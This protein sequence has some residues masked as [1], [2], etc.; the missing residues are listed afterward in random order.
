MD[1]WLDSLSEDWVSQPR[2]P[3]SSPPVLSNTS[4]DSPSPSNYGSQSRIPR[5]KPR[6][7]SGLSTESGKELRPAPSMR[8][9]SEQGALKEKSS[10]NINASQKRLPNGQ[11]KS[12][13]LNAASMRLRGRQASTGSTSPLQQ[14]TVQHKVSPMKASDTQETLE[15]KTRLL[16]ENMGKG[17]LFSPIGLEGVFKPP[18]VNAKAKKPMGRRKLFPMEDFPSSPPQYPDHAKPGKA[19]DLALPQRDLLDE[20]KSS[21]PTANTRKAALSSSNGSPDRSVIA[22]TKIA[23]PNSNALQSPTLPMQKTRSSLSNEQIDSQVSS[24]GARRSEPGDKTRNENISPLYVSRHNTVDGRVEFAAIDMSV[25]RLRSEMEKLR[26]QQQNLPSSRSSDHGIDYTDA[27]LGGQSMLHDRMDEATSQSLPDDLSMGTDAFAANGGFVSLH[28]GGYSN[29][30]SFQRR[31][32]SPSLLPDLDGP[33]LKLPSSTLDHEGRNGGGVRDDLEFEQQET[34]QTAKGKRL[35]CSP[36]KD[37]APKRRRTIRNPDEADEKKFELSRRMETQ[38][39]PVQS[40]HGRKRKDARYDIDQQAADPDAI[41]RRPMLRPR[42]PTLNRA[43]NHVRQMNAVEPSL[44]HEQWRTEDQE[45]ERNQSNQISVD[46]PTQIVAGALATVALNTVQEITGGSRKASVTTAD[47]FNEAQQIMQLLRAKGRPR[48]SHTTAETSEVDHPTI[49]EESVV[50]D[51]TKDEFSRPP[52]R[53]GPSPPKL[54]PPAQLNPRVVSHLRKFEDKEDLG[55]ALSSSL[56]N[57]QISQSNEMSAPNRDDTEADGSESDPPNTRIREST[58]QAH[59]RS[60]SSSTDN[61]LSLETQRSQRY[62]S[63]QSTSGPSTSRSNPTGSSHSSTNRMVIAPETVAHLLAD[64]MAGMAYDHQRQVWVRRKS[65]PK[66]GGMD[67]VDHSA[68]EGTEEDFFR[69]IPDLSVDEMEELQR[70]KE[71]VSSIRSLGSTKDK[72]SVHDLAVS[73][74][75]QAKAENRDKPAVDVRPKTADGKYIDPIDNSSAPSKY[76]HFAF[77]GPAPGTSTR[78]TS[79]GDDALP[80]KEVH[81]PAMARLAVPRNLQEDYDPEVE[82]EISILEGRASPTPHRQN[83]HRQAR[84]VT[85]AFSSPLVDHGELLDEPRD[86]YNLREGNSKW[87]LEDT[88]ARKGT[89]RNLFSSRRTSFGTSKPAARST[90]RRQSISNQSY[91]ARPMSRL[92]EQDEMSLVHCSIG[93]RHMSMKVAVSTPIPLSRSLIAPPMTSQQSGVG[94]FLSPLPDFTV[95]QVDRPVD[96]DLKQT[97]QRR[98]VLPNATAD[99]QL[100][101]AAQDLVKTLTDLQ[102]YEPYWE[103]IRSV[104]LHNR[105]LRSLHMLDEFCGRVEELDVSKNQ[106]RELSGI[107]RSVR[108]L[109][110]RGNCLSDLSAWHSLQNLQYLDVSGNELSSLRGFGCLFHLRALRADDNKLES[111]DGV[112]RLDGL[113][114][115]SL[116]GNKLQTVDF[117]NYDLRRLTH[118]NLSHNELIEVTNMHQLTA[119]ET[120]NLS[121]NDLE[122]LDFSISDPLHKLHTLNISNNKL[123]FIDLAEVPNI[124][125]LNIDKNSVGSIESL[126]GLKHLETLSWRQQDLIPAYGFSEIQYQ[127]CHEVRSLFLSGNHLATFAPSTPFLN[128]HLLELASTGLKTLPSD[129]GLKC[130]NL[131]SLNVNYN[132]IQ[133]L[134]PLLGVL[135]LE[136]LHAAGNR[137]SKLRRTVS[138]LQRLCLELKE[139]DLRSNPLTLGYYTPQESVQGEKCVA[140]QSYKHNADGDD[141]DAEAKAAKAYVLPSVDKEADNASR[142]R[143]DEDTKIRRRVY[144]M[145]VV[146]TC[147]QLQQLDGLPV[148]RKLVGKRDRVWERLVELGVLNGKSAMGTEDCIE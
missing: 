34:I 93:D 52:S 70:V 118:M 64:E 112:E 125:D 45:L 24:D 119:L 57:L 89:Q 8:R 111:M 54:G 144:E 32:V 121:Y 20:Q 66:I 33:S 138:V 29:D 40:S 113:I 114:S 83:K 92:D 104:D 13:G 46:A 27:G 120:C 48:S 65:T 14:D 36:A 107:P 67:N 76:S 87:D 129:F 131:R 137:V 26:M 62:H 71:A 6:T 2:S 9:S 141:E 109:N 68:S 142:E 97:T 94:F 85:V 51:S 41:A 43:S 98:N 15:W 101:L 37:P 123:T 50:E 17:D 42:A 12:Q 143:L 39:A 95:N 96:R 16:K 103:H 100:S 3:H 28:R 35:S 11:V 19:T 69:D 55:L 1:Q 63:S 136:T 117:E 108:L 102:P 90:S 22:N 49:V 126:N 79:W 88:P 82:H 4:K 145:M 7:T 139:V 133:D 21:A 115:L 110:I 86:G 99:N 106:I 73:A 44:A 18:T 124:K 80:P 130:P 116:Q 5:Y 132:A 47:F 25:R 60:D 61:P 78:A 105:D 122:S 135:K 127:H 84:V 140:L 148:S 74:E 81:L 56:K 75:T 30:G 146:H 58:I 72:V 134:R 23:E 77:S 91:L 59:K 10:S 128:L 38:E 147:K 53:E 31:P